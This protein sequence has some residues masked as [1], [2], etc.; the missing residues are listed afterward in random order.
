MRFSS[1]VGVT[2]LVVALTFACA[3]AQPVPNKEGEPAAGGAT[4]GSPE[5][6]TPKGAPAA[7]EAEESGPGDQGMAPGK[8]KGKTATKPS[9]ENPN[10]RNEGTAERK[11]TAEGAAK[12]GEG[13]DN[14]ANENKSD[15]APKEAEEGKSGAKG[16]HGKAAKIEPKQVEKVKT[17]FHEHRP[18]VKRVE[19]S[20]VSVSI[21]IAL[22]GT[23]ALYPVPA[24]VVEITGGCPLE[25]FVWEDDVVLV[26]SCSREV[27]DIIPGAA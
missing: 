22:P 18:T 12:E 7:P 9:D 23:I 10:G 26:D 6:G 20:A 4:A 1:L 21:G 27:V 11:G 8:Q 14:P 17:Y 15:R 13:S 19:R 3:Y 25:Y 5:V 2:S 24:G 16:E